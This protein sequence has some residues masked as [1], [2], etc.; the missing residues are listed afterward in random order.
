MAYPLHSAVESLNVETSG[1]A[2]SDPSNM[3]AGFLSFRN[4]SSYHVPG[5][6]SE[7]LL[8]PRRFAGREAEGIQASTLVGTASHRLNDEGW[9]LPARDGIDDSDASR[10]EGM[11]LRNTE[12]SPVSLGPA[13]RSGF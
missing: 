9:F 6:E 10:I 11:C 8:R 1:Y 2:N 12:A 4:K 3:D 7:D 13:A 5:L